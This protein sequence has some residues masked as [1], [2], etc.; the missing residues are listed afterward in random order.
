MLTEILPEDTRY[1]FNISNRI[2]PI[3]YILLYDNKTMCQVTHN[4][5]TFLT[6]L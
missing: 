3:K 1:V 6:H 5:T 4:Y 2:K